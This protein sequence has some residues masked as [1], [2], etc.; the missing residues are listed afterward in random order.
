MSFRVI[1]SRVLSTY[2]VY[3]MAHVPTTVHLSIEACRHIMSV[4]AL[5]WACIP[6]MYIFVGLPTEVVMTALLAQLYIY[7]QS[8]LVFIQFYIL[9]RKLSCNVA[10]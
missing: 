7:V 2:C 10:L 1:G 8:E 5:C 9:F 3:I 4:S 6:C